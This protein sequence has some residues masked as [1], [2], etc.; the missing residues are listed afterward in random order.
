MPSNLGRRNNKREVL[1]KA[2]EL[3]ENILKRRTTSVNSA[4]REWVAK[5]GGEIQYTTGTNSE[6][7]CVESRD[8]FIMKLP[9]DSSGKRDNF[10]IAHEIGHFLLHCDVEQNPGEPAK[11]NR[12]GGGTDPM[13][14]EANWFAAE[15]LMPED[16]FRAAAKEN[17]DA[18]SLAASFE[19]SPSA[20]EVRMKALGIIR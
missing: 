13:E 16:A 7:L 3:H 17:N 11:F 14:W 19:V 12:G 20:A 18:A 5:K 4:L 8:N 10:T 2:R 1:E 15:L 6:S 9:F